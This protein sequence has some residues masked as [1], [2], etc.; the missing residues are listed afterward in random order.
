MKPKNVFFILVLLV[1]SSCSPETIINPVETDETS[2]LFE[3]LTVVDTTL[4][5]IPQPKT[6]IAYK[7]SCDLTSIRN[8]DI[9]N[10]SLRPASVYVRT[11]LSEISQQEL[12]TSTG[13][14]KNKQTINLLLE[15]LS[16][17]TEHYKLEIAPD[18]ISV[19][20]T[21]PQAVICGLNTLR[22][23]ISING[24][25][26][27]APSVLPCVALNDQPAFSWRAFMLDVARHFFTKDE[28]C[29]IIDMMAQLK[30]N[31][32]HLHLTDDQG[33]R[34]P[35][36]QYPEL[37]ETGWKRLPND[38]DKDCI[39]L[40]KSFP[41]Y[42]FPSDRWDGTY[43]FGKYSKSDI[44]ELVAYAAERGIDIIPEIDIPGHSSVAIEAHPE[45]SCVNGT[46]WGE[47]FS[48]PLCLGNDNVLTYYKNIF[49][50]LMILFPSKYIHVGADEADPTN[51]KSC[52][53]CQARIKNNN[54]GSVTGLQKWF[55]SQIEQQIRS[56]GRKMVV[57][58]DALVS[59][60]STAT[61]MWW[62]DWIGIN[63]AVGGAV[64]QGS[65]AVIT[66]WDVMYFSG[67]ETDNSLAEI[68]NL[69]LYP[70]N[71]ITEGQKS[72]VVGIQGSVFTEVTPN[73]SRLNYM[74]YPRMFAL[75]EKSWYADNTNTEMW[76]SFKTR[77]NPWLLYLKSKNIRY[78]TPNLN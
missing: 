9:Q 13:N 61:V 47:E 41:D 67:K 56:K 35:I 29:N 58:D 57:W 55:L 50:E 71:G 22:Q 26:N 78:R 28:I 14:I 45:F 70:T 21:T 2:T 30:L 31:K 18:N 49:D 74:I 60:G 73:I 34:I 46:G 44:Q 59:V 36:N 66:N 76:T 4:A 6:L 64:R 52:P 8:I 19:T 11:I 7:G 77:L 15:P 12:S 62:R 72:L 33:W 53:K 16:N 54:L 42:Q 51:W 25:T 27:S 5:I 10:E 69:R 32:L 3:G 17:N 65:E 63:N 75:S 23:I 48:Y 40:A 37:I 68:Y 24:I 38:H 43:Y 39:N 20:G 1:V